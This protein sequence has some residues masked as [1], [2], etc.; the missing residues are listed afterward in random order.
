M[1]INRIAEKKRKDSCKFF[2]E[3]EDNCGLMQFKINDTVITTNL[4]Q[5]IFGMGVKIGDKFYST[6]DISKPNVEYISDP[7]F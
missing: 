3:L 2:I 1:I 6:F 4:K 5:G 7:N